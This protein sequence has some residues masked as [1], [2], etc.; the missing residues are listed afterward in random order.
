MFWILVRENAAI[1]QI[2]LADAK[3]V[4]LATI[5]RHFGESRSDK[6]GAMDCP[7]IIIHGRVELLKARCYLGFCL[8]D[9]T[10]I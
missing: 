2:E 3:Y 10:T 5:K 6:E 1:T 8:M 9:L 4:S 7:L